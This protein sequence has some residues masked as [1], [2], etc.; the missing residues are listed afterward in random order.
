MI[1]SYFVRFLT[2]LNFFAARIEEKGIQPLLDILESLGGWPVLKGDQWDQ[3]SSWTWV[4]SVGDFRQQG[5]STD[6]FFDFSV[7]TDLKNST[8]RIIDVR[9][10]LVHCMLVSFKQPFPCRQ[11]K[12]LWALAAST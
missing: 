7:G 1:L 6:Y 2:F 11:I 12:L 4:K 3:D 10:L 5:Y 9:I 8:R